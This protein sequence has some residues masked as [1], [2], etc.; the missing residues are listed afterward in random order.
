MLDFTLEDLDCLSD[1]EFETLEREVSRL[2]ACWQIS[3]MR[4]AS[5]IYW[6]DQHIGEKRHEF[7]T[8]KNTSVDVEAEMAFRRKAVVDSLEGNSLVHPLTTPVIVV[9]QTCTKA[10]CVYRSFGV[11]GLSKFRETP[12]AIISIGSVPGANVV[13]DGEWKRLWGAWLR[14]TKNE[15][16]AGWVENMEPTNTRPPLTPEQDRAMMGRFA[17]QKDELRKRAP[18]PPHEDTWD[19]FPDECDPA[20]QFITL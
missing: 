10:R 18:E 15:Y 17:Y 14:L 9:D 8:L 13:E 1:E 2:T 5:A 7:M 19:A 12:T 6:D 16:H 4:G 11:E 20:W 3:N